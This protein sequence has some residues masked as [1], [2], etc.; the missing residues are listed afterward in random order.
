VT[1]EPK[2]CVTCKHCTVIADTHRCRKFPDIVTGE[3]T[4][5]RTLRLGEISERKC[6]EV[7]RYYERRE[8][9]SAITSADN[10]PIPSPKLGTLRQE[11]DPAVI[12]RI[13]KGATDYE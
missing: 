2:L 1:D 3:G 7:G 12:A 10:P 9:V 11:D 5:C 8:N 4:L 13:M 6:G